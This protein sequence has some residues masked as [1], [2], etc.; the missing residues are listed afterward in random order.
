MPQLSGHSPA[1]ASAAMAGAM[2]SALLALACTTIPVGT[3]PTGAA[4]APNGN[5]YVNN[6]TSAN[7][8]AINGATNTVIT[9]L[10]AGTNPYETVAAPTGK[11]YV[12]NRVS[13]KVTVIDSVTNTVVATLPAHTNPQYVAVGPTATSTSPTSVRATSL[14]S[15][16]TRH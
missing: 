2:P 13:G 10:P 9:T 12:P 7:V 5:V 1:L 3:Q 14:S 15:L 8:K 6:S 11:I 4:V 16:P